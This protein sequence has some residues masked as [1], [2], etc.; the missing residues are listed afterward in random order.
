MEE[1]GE[2]EREGRYDG[3]EEEGRVGG[4]KREGKMRWGMI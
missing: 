2:S 4:R 3:N 1:E